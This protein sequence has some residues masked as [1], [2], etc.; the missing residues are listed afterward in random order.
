[1][2]N[3]QNRY[4]LETIIYYN[5]IPLIYDTRASDFTQNELIITINWMESLSKFKQ[6]RKITNKKEHYN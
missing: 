1:M 3:H 6:T 4:M 2:E 5:W